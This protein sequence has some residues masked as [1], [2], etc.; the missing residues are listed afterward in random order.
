MDKQVRNFQQTLNQLTVELPKIGVNNT[1]E[2]LAKSLFFV[3][4]GSNDFLANYL[5]PASVK[6]L[7]YTVDQFIDLLI[8]KFSKQLKVNRTRAFICIYIYIFCCVYN[9]IY[10]S[11]G[12]LIV[13]QDLYDLGG[14]RFLVCGI[15]PLGC[16]PNQVGNFALNQ[17]EC[18]D[19]PNEMAAKYNE[20]LKPLL[21]QLKGDL[22]GANFVYGEIYFFTLNILNN[23][24]QY[25]S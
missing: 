5:L 3:S 22:P 2:F 14:R 6:A 11:R 18:F 17:S 1:E 9:K 20:K 10:R 24:S 7:L 21:T 15:G 23:P 16:I 12:M 8:S 13:L 25:G 19:P 4:I